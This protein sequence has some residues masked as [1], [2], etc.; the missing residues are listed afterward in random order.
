MLDGHPDLSGFWEIIDPLRRHIAPP[1]LT[2]QASA[3]GESD[4]VRA[5][6]RLAAGFQVGI[7]AY[8]CQMGVGPSWS[9]QSEPIDILQTPEQTL[10]II[11]RLAPAWRIYTD[12]RALPDVSRMP[13]SYNGYSVGHWEGD[14][15]VVQTTGI[16]ILDTVPRPGVRGGG[17][18]T[19]NTRLTL[20]MKLI[21]EGRQLYMTATYEDPAVYLKPHVVE[22]TF[23]RNEPE[24]YAFGYY[25]D[26]TDPSA[27]AVVEPPPQ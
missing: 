26:P 27:T 25:C 20:R 13:P 24:T 21:S 10:I 3:H 6:A 8:L 5:A 16:R 23:F 18:T 1:E 14:T 17:Y 2:P 11:E 19:P 7:G 22:Y 9:G 4:R 15:F 12:G